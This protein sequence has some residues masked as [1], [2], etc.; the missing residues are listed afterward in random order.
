MPK[1][2]IFKKR[3]LDLNPRYDPV[4]WILYRYFFQVI[5]LLSG[6]LFMAALYF[7]VEALCSQEEKPVVVETELEQ[8][9][10]IQTPEGFDL[11]SFIPKTLARDDEV[12]L[13]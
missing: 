2:G 13:R 8:T 10:E 1:K 7:I 4:L 3:K 12:R 6:F 5:L 11:E 9:M